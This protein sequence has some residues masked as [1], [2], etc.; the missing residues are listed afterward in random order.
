LTWFGSFDIASNMKTTVDIPKPLLEK[1]RHLV[2]EQR[3]TFRTLVEEGLEHVLVQRANRKPFKLKK[4]PTA[5][6]GFKP[7]FDEADWGS[8]RDE[9]YKGRGT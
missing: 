7:G 3:V 6:G 9:I 4:A 5:G 1:C 2:R 8:I